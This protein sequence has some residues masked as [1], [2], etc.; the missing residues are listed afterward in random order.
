MDEKTIPRPVLDYGRIKLDTEMVLAYHV[1]QSIRL[2]LKAHGITHGWAT[3]RQALSTHYRVTTSM[4]RLDGKVLYLRK[5]AKPEECHT[6][7]YNALGLPSRPGK[8]SKTTL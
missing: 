3:I 2:K 5:T 8:T 4:K 7:I 1:L 6:R